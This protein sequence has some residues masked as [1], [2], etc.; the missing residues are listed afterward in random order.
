MLEQMAAG[1]TP[2]IGDLPPDVG[3]PVYREVLTTGDLPL[4]DVQVEDR[5][6]P[7]AAGPLPV[8]VYTPKG[9]ITGTRGLVLKY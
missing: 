1:G 3:R 7:G 5:C 2:D 9:K 8:R 6:I 4:A